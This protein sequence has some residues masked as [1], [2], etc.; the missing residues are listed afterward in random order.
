MY[1]L[2]IDNIPAACY[3]PLREQIMEAMRARD[4]ATLKR[5]PGTEAKERDTIEQYADRLKELY[6]DIGTV[7]ICE[8]LDPF[9]LFSPISGNG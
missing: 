3:A 9:L 8:G 2:R 5:L 6:P 4:L 7:S 1:H